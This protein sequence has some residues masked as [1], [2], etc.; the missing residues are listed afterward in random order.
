MPIAEFERK[1]SGLKPYGRTAMG[2]AVGLLCSVL[3]DKDLMPAKSYPPV[4]VMISDGYSTDEDKY[5]ASIE[6]LN[7]TPWGAKASRNVISIGTE[8][9]EDSLRLFT[10]DRGAYIDCQNVSDLVNQIVLRTTIAVTQTTVGNGGAENNISFDGNVMKN[11]NAD[12]LKKLHDI[13]DNKDDLTNYVPI[14]DLAKMVF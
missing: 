1:Y 13:A 12:S 7:K 14:D 9:D 10:N 5:S 6:R 8:T 2:M 3:E 4:C 11:L